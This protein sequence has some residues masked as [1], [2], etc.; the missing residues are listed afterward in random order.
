MEPPGGFWVFTRSRILFLQEISMGDG[1]R[2]QEA[3]PL[4]ALRYTSSG[5]MALKP[6][7]AIS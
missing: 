2:L 4:A 6:L 3:L 7:V 1:D 5:C